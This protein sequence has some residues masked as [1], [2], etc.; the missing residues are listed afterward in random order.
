LRTPLDQIRVASPCPISWEQMT[1]DN[2]VRFCDECQLNVYNIA[3]LTRTEVED[4]LRTTEGRLCGRLYRRAD[5]TVITKDCPVGLRAVRRRVARVATAAFA[6]MVS[7]CSA[8]VGQKQS[9]KDKACRQQVKI[10]L[11]T[12]QAADTTTV[13]GTILDP[14][15]AVVAGAHVRITD[16]ITKKTYSFRSDDEG[17]FSR[18]GL[19]PSTYEVLIE[20]PGFKLLKIP[21][22]K[23]VAGQTAIL[24]ATLLVAEESVTVGI[25]AEDSLID[26]TPGIKT[27]ISGDKIRKLP[28]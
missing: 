14:N 12:N 23:I 17:R 20:S 2:R 16:P 13:T 19:P 15:G 8:A 24:E 26:T 9:D 25:I 7:L 22:V 21:R 18:S 28:Y 10:T 3:E 11:K 1:G 6:T 5:G 4:L 27:T